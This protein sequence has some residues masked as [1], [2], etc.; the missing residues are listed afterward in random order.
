[1]DL[2]PLIVV[3][4]LLFWGWLLGPMGALVAVPLTIGMKFFFESF[5]ESL[6]LAHLMSDAGTAP[7]AEKVSSESASA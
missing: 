3:I 1:V 4:S 5:D 7:P 6:W 2:S